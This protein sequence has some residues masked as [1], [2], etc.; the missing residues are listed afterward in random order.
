MKLNLKAFALTTAIL[1][2][3][4]SFVLTLSSV[5]TGF[6][7]EF[8]ELIAPFHPGYTHTISGVFI[9]AF[10]MFIYGLIAGVLFSSLYNS[11]LK[12]KE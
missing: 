2:G 9:S 11:F 8:L 7:K 3:A 12:G 4:G 6:A 1:S 10:W 5:L